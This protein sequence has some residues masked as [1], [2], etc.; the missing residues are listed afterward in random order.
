MKCIYCIQQQWLC[1]GDRL[2]KLV[3]QLYN[4]KNCSAN[5]MVLILRIPLLSSFFPLLLQ[6]YFIHSFHTPLSLPLN[7]EVR[8]CYNLPAGSCCNPI[9]RGF[10]CMDGWSKFCRTVD[11]ARL[12]SAT[13]PS[14]LRKLERTKAHWFPTHHSHHPP[15]L[16]SFIPGLKP[17]FSANPSQ[18]N[19][20]SFSGL[21][22]W[23]P[24]LFTDTSEHI[25]FL[26][27]YTVSPKR[28]PF[29]S[30]KTLSKINRFYWFFCMLNPEKKFDV[31]ILHVCPS[32]LSD[33]ATLPW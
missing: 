14:P 22:P 26:I 2:I 18:R 30:W 17:F 24:R 25:R 1:D 23:I 27:F 7:Y 21:T 33:V 32:H 19:L 13:N 10:W 8:E 5:L 6:S 20:F 15:P 29:I 9:A 12:S 3:Q 31:K 16:Y 4:N 11:D 28:Q